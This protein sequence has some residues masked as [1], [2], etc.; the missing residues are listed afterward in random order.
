M[1]NPQKH[2][3]G[4]HSSVLD[5]GQGRYPMWAGLHQGITGTQAWGPQWEA[6]CMCV[7]LWECGLLR[8]AETTT[9]TSATAGSGEPANA[10]ATGHWHHTPLPRGLR[11]VWCSRTDRLPTVQCQPPQGDLWIPR[12]HSPSPAGFLCHRN[13]QGILKL[14]R[15]CNELRTDQRILIKNHIRGHALPDFQTYYKATVIKRAWRGHKDRQ[16]NWW[17]S[18]QSADVDSHTADWFLSKGPRQFNWGKIIFLTDG[19]GK[20]GYPYRK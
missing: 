11:A 14:I 5:Y 18:T 2:E 1:I 20:T 13:C 3:H 12:N 8:M 15:K 19:A 4:T 16:L 17:S 10:C 9:S 6:P 7:S